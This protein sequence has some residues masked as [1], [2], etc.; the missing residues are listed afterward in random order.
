MKHRIVVL[1]ALVAGCIQGIW[2]QS[3]IRGPYLTCARQDGIDIHWRTST[4]ATGLVSYG[5]HPD[6]LINTSSH[7][8][9]STDH[10]ITLNNLSS[11][12]LYYYRIGTTQFTLA[13]D[14]SFHFRTLQNST[15]MADSVFRIWA[16][17]DIGKQTTQQAEV[18]DAFLK[19]NQGRYLDAW[20][21]LG[22]IAY[23]DGTDSDYQLGFF[24]YYQ[25]SLLK[26]TVLWPS[27]GNHDYANNYTLRTSHAVPY[28]SI[29]SLPQQGQS[30][31]LSSG[32]ARYYSWNNGPVH[33]I[34]L[35]SY[36]LDLVQNNFYGLADTAFSPQVNWL[37]NDLAQNTKPWVIV[38]FH[39]P[40]YCMGTHDSDVEP[41]LV[42]IRQ[43]LNPIFE[44]YNVDLVLNGH[45]HSYQRS[46]GLRGHYGM[47]NSF[48]STIHRVLPG[49]GNYT[50]QCPYIKHP[51]DTATFYAVIG[52]GGAVPQAPMPNWPHNAMIYSNFQDNGSLLLEIQGNRLDGIWISNDTT[53]V[54]KDRFTIYKLPSSR[55]IQFANFPTTIT[56]QPLWTG[57]RPYQWSTGD[58]ADSIT[59]HLNQDSLFIVQDATG[60]LRDSI[61]IFGAPLSISSWDESTIRVFPNPAKNE[62][63]VQH[64]PQGSYQVNLYTSGGEKILSHEKECQDGQIRLTIQHI[65]DEF[66]FLELRNDKNQIIHRKIQLHEGQ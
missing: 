47:E 41:D 44:R 16:V 48:D 9:F 34:H 23:P 6:S 30:G 17:G 26:N 2:S 45:C 55:R 37:K 65:N 20:I 61:W 42:G 5:T 14:S 54:V 56:L 66:I 11:G 15:P 52:S 19:Y 22:D 35:D 25:N 33:F 13:G 10:L 58:T 53:Q 60:C 27:I 51:G 7:L 46:G 1:V 64:L 3:L 8:N 39:H 12:T 4:P 31:G 28:M 38:S 24:T 32:S 63:I 62:I 40:P 59:L 50:D 49:N 36:G 57:Q 21:V 43:H 18:R 29:F